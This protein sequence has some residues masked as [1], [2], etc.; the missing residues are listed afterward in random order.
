MI[1]VTNLPEKD[2]REISLAYANDLYPADEK[3]HV[4]L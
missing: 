2:L 1:Q 3:V 4:P